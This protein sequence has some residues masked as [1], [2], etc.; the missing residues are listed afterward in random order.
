MIMCRTG[1]WLLQT[2]SRIALEVGHSYH[3]PNRAAPSAVHIACTDQ[4]SLPTQCPEAPSSSTGAFPAEHRDMGLTFAYLYTERPMC[5]YVD[6]THATL[7]SIVMASTHCDKGV[8]VPS[9]QIS[10]YFLGSVVS[11]FL[12]FVAL[13]F[14]FFILICFLFCFSLHC[15]GRLRFLHSIYI[16]FGLE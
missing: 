14:R 15:A 8:A 3:S 1:A 13:L 7:D 6:R 9:W 16:S 11:S 10:R 5:A 4:V 2:L 12:V